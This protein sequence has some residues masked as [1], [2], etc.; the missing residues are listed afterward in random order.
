M[1]LNRMPDE[2]PPLSGGG[3]RWGKD[4]V[5]A[6]KELDRRTTNNSGEIRRVNGVANGAVQVAVGAQQQ[7]DNNTAIVAAVPAAPVGLTTLVNEAGFETSG[8]PYARVVVSWTPV[9]TQESGDPLP[10]GVVVNG[11]EVWVDVFSQPRMVG[12]MTYTGESNPS[13]EARLEVNHAYNM[14]VRARTSSGTYGPF[15]AA[16]SVTTVDQMAAALAPTTP[17]LLSD[18]GVVVATWDGQVLDGVTPVVKPAWMNYIYAEYSTVGATGPWTRSGQTLNGAGS[19]TI[20]GPAVGATVWV[21]LGG[22]TTAGKFGPYS[23]VA[24]TTVVGVDLGALDEEVADAIQQAVDAAEAAQAAANGKNTVHHELTAP[25]GSGGVAGD[26][27]FQY[28]GGELNAVI[29]LWIWDGT[30]W[31]P[32]ALDNAVIASLDA[33]KINT[34]YLAAERIEAGS[35]ATEH[36]AAGSITTDKIGANQ[37]TANEIAAGTIT[38]NE[39]AAGTITASSLAAGIGGELDISANGSIELIAG[40]VSDVQTNVDA[41]DDSLAEM[42]T[43]YTFGPTGAIVST[44]DSPFAVAI[45]NDRIEMMESG[46]VVSYWN[47]GQ[48]HVSS[49]VAEEI[50]LGNHKLQKYGTGSVVRAL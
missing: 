27:W 32:H 31:E 18:L 23:T 22:T 48:M 26:L 5:E 38:S 2:Q 28:S 6:L 4:V 13:A 34:G 1:A 21:R 10:A 37:V 42:Q 29:G 44:P 7:T 40:Q 41:V 19:V 3:I 9:T 25:V 49:L 50:V 47:A 36:L 12:T 33:G 8:A 35:I 45:R 15:S 39:I 46:V 43:Y 20:V 24:S 17:T 30:S 14:Y 11:Y 16:L